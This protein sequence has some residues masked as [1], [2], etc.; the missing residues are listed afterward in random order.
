MGEKGGEGPGLARN[1]TR[2]V[3]QQCPRHTQMQREGIL[4]EDCAIKQGEE[5][6]HP[7]VTLPCTI[8]KE[9][10]TGGAVGSARNWER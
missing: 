1:T 5:I 4:C 2:S 10:W 9:E 7:Y 3:R 8:A 6:S